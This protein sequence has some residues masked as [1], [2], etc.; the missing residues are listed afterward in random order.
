VVRPAPSISRF[1]PASSLCLCQPIEFWHRP[2]GSPGKNVGAWPRFGRTMNQLAGA[3]FAGAQ[4]AGAQFDPSTT[5]TT[6]W[7]SALIVL[8]R[9]ASSCRKRSKLD[10]SETRC[11]NRTPRLRSGHRELAH[12]EG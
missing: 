11:P 5:T 2:A 12:I 10:H 7:A 9:R 1:D 3:Q 4:F 6:T 8:L